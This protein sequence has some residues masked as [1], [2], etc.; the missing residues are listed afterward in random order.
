M[1]FDKDV[2]VD[3]LK[4][5]VCVVTFTKADGSERVMK[6]TLIPEMLPVVENKTTRK[7]APNEDVVAA[8]DLEVAGFRSFRLDSIK[9]F[10]VV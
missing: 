10:E 2:V 4:K 8:Y 6:C 3:T 7:K 5:R 9:T 1:E